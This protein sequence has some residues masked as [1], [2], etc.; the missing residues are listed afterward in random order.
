M[1][2][3]FKFL[4]SWHLIALV[5][6]TEQDLCL[7]HGA[8][9]SQ[10]QTHCRAEKLRLCSSSVRDHP[11]DMRKEPR[12]GSSTRFPR[13]GEFVVT[14]EAAMEQRVVAGSQYS[15]EDACADLSRAWISNL[16][17]CAVQWW[18]LAPRAG[19]RMIAVVP[20]AMHVLN[21]FCTQHLLAH[22]SMT[23]SYT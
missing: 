14:V 16:S 23:S 21:C 5:I 18:N 7:G 20:F 3:G 11:R 15:L 10:S 9:A 12:K 17:S 8:A 22:G 19:G 6:L 4:G 13:P 1:P 2:E